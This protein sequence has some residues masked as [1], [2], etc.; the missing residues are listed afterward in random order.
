MP[1]RSRRHRSGS[2]RVRSRKGSRFE[3]SL[4]LRNTV[5]SSITFAFPSKLLVN[6]GSIVSERDH[7]QFTYYH[8]ELER[9]GVL[10]AENTP[11]ESYLDTGNRCLFDNADVPRQLYPSFELD[12]D[13][14][15]LAYR[16]LRTTG[17]GARTSDADLGATSGALAGNRLSNT[18][19]ANNRRCG[20]S[21]SRRWTS[22]P[23]GI[24]SRRTL[25]FPCPRGRR[26]GFPDVPLGHSRRPH[27]CAP[28]RYQAIGRLRD[29]DRHSCQRRRSPHS[30]RSPRA[31]ERL[32]RNRER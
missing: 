9:H 30:R 22:R 5:W 1:I 31:G 29:L 26:I 20:Y 19:C 27:G 14:V 8:I 4:F 28:A 24:G 6:G 21:S 15:A 3:I 23:T 17:E 12:V 2:A 11:S 10:L 32:E 13:L 7:T 25:P 16:C 18:K